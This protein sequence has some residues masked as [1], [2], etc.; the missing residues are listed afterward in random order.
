MSSA[1]RE[2]IAALEDYLR[3]Y[4]SGH[5]TELAQL[6]LDRLL[7]QLGEKQVQVVSSPANPFSKGTVRANT[8]YR[9]GDRYQYQVIDLLTKVPGA[10]RVQTVTALSDSEVIYN[11]GKPVTDLLGNLIKRPDGATF[12]PMQYFATEYSVGRKWGTR[13]SVVLANGKP[14]IVEL[15]F[16][17]V[18]REDVTVPA[19]TFDCFRVEGEGWRLGTSGVPPQSIKT[20]Y[21]VA[22]QRVARFVAMETWWRIGSRITRSDRDELVQFAPGA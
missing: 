17:V 19:G 20:T 2:A 6:R 5:F 3:R 16:R 15:D 8:A 10:H 4:P 14:D 21:W 1:T 22:P 18:T 12:G 7:A 13:Y 9:V 11:D